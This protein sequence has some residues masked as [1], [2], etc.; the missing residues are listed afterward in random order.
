VNNVELI[1]EE[2]AKRILDLPPRSES[3]GG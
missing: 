2:L 1:D 3:D